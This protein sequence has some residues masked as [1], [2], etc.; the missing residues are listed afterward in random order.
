MSATHVT[1]APKADMAP[2]E[3]A[4]SDVGCRPVRRRPSDA[5]PN[6]LSITPAQFGLMDEAAHQERESATDAG[7]IGFMARMLVQVTMPHSKPETDRFIR[8]NGGFTVEMVAGKQRFGLPYGSIP[9]L[10]LAWMT[11]EAVRT[12]SSTLELGRSFSA[13]VRAVGLVPEGGT[14]SGGK[15]GVGTLAQRQTLALLNAIVSWNYNER[16]RDRGQNVTIAD[17]Y[18]IAWDPHERSDDSLTL[19]TSKVTLS[20][21]FFTEMTASPV[22]IDLR[23][24]K[25]LKRSP[26]RLDIYSWLTW[27]MFTVKRP[28]Q[29]PWEYLKAQFGS[30]YADD[31]HGLRNFR[32]AFVEALNAVMLFYSAANVGFDERVLTLRPSPTHVPELR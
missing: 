17:D 25:A 30:G 10:V 7:S 21:K 6:P 5:K 2:A 27:R 12:Q 14:I 28:T 18:D 19:W 9:R 24:L 23:A 11:T 8:S 26:M 22:P 31:A 3:R 20:P 4:K 32:Q 16:K 29:I 15:R 13:F 1:V